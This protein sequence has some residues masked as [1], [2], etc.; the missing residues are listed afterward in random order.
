MLSVS[1]LQTEKLFILCVEL[2]SFQANINISHDLYK[3]S[4]VTSLHHP[5]HMI[6]VTYGQYFR[7]TLLKYSKIERL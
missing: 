5:S 7:E 4:C 1:C 6:Q 2:M 3:E